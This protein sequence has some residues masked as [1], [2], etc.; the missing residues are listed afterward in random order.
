MTE[1]MR[2]VTE[3]PTAY[4]E[5]FCG[6][7]AVFFHLISTHA[8]VPGSAM[9]SDANPALMTTYRVVRDET[10]LLLDHLADAEREYMERD[11]PARTDMYYAIRQ[12]YN[13][14]TTGPQAQ[15]DVETAWRFIFLNRT[16]FNAIM[17]YNRS[18]QM[19]TPFGHYVRPAIANAEVIRAAALALTHV[20]IEH[21]DFAEAV[22]S[23]PPKS[24]V[25]IDPPYRGRS[26]S[27]N[28]TAYTSGGF[29]ESE[30]RRLCD[31]AV[32]LVGRGVQVVLSNAAVPE[33]VSLYVKAGFSVRIVHSRRSV[34]A[35]SASRRAVPEVIITSPH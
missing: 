5:P 29:S 26:V 34:A 15:P 25:Y 30:Q 31:V 8:L 27:A 9:L 1:I 2:E 19:N 23:A 17:R 28:F 18:G 13:D 16:A 21:L 3:R 11:A 35:S 14:I 20:R 22:A 24:L 4:F 7:G 12:E 10:E 6:G 33:I 32:D